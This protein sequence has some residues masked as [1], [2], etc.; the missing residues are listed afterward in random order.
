[1]LRVVGVT[2]ELR[3]VGVTTAERRATN[4]QLIFC[5]MLSGRANSGLSLP[6]R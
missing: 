2:Y 1:M 3:V 5:S 6:S 4:M